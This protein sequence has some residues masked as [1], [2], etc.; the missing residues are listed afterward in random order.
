MTIRHT[1]LAAAIV[2]TPQ[3]DRVALH[4]A[5]LNAKA[6]GTKKGTQHHNDWEESTFTPAAAP[7]GA[8]QCKQCQA[9]D[10]LL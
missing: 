4:A 3:I 6:T 1:S 2:V 7:V 10:G 8:G 5:H 9:S